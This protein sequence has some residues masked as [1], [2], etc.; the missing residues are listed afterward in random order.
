MSDSQ[1]IYSFYKFIENNI[2]ILF[3]I[4]L[5]VFSIG[6]M[7]YWENKVRGW[8]RLPVINLLLFIVLLFSG[9]VEEIYLTFHPNERTKYIKSS[10]FQRFF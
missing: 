8:L 2:F 4:V 5:S 6:L 9:T 1:I 7:F 10:I 3:G